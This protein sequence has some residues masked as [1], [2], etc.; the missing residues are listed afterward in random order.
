[1]TYLKEVISKASRLPWGRTGKNHG[2][3]LCAASGETVLDVQGY[4]TITFHD[5]DLIIEAVNNLPHLLK[6]IEDQNKSI[7]GY[8]K[9]LN[10]ARKRYEQLHK[11]HHESKSNEEVA[12]LVRECVSNWNDV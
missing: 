5:V 1:M 11:I 7:E 6:V 8:T 3:M 2:P 4:V 9:C 12:K 10:V